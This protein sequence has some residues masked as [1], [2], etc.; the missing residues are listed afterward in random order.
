[1]NAA[2][3]TDEPRRRIRRRVS[4]HMSVWLVGVWVV[5]RADYTLVSVLVGVVFATALQLVFP[6]PRLGLITRVR[7]VWLGVLAA[8]FLVDLTKAALEVSRII[9]RPQRPR[10]HV[11]TVTLRSQSPLYLTISSALTSLV[12][13]TVV[14]DAH[15]RPATL[16]L[17]VLDIDDAAGANAIALAQIRLE[18]RIMWAIAPGEELEKRGIPGRGRYSALARGEAPEELASMYRDYPVREE[19]S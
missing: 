15:L 14:M 6:M 5:L 4:F 3:A 8:V 12:P 17:H 11:V 13:G 7:P 16:H 10:P 19:T 1:M 9:V 18:E 2:V